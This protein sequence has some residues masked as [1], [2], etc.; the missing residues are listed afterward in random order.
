[1]PKKKTLLALAVLVLGL[2]LFSASALAKRPVTSEEMV[3]WDLKSAQIIEAGKAVP[4]AEGQFITGY[5]LEAQAKSKSGSVLPNA[6]FRLTLDAFSP[7][8]DMGRQK[9]GFWYI[10]GQWTLAPS[11]AALEKTNKQHNPEVVTGYVA[12]ELPFNPITSPEPWTGKALAPMA[13]AAGSW[14]RGEGSLTFSNGLKGSLFLDLN[15][16]SEAK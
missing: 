16:W 13:M 15:R 6:V 14:S 11:A 7:Y 9:A 1:M 4:M 10:Q 3:I 2:A 8:S 12:A 5:V